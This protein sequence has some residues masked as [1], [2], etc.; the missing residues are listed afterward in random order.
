MTQEEKKELIM[1]LCGYLPYDLKVDVC[2]NDGQNIHSTDIVSY[3]NISRCV[4]LVEGD[5]VSIKPYLRP[6]S[7]MTPEEEKEFVKFHC[8]DLCPIIMDDC[9]TIENETEMIN[10]L[11]ARHFDYRK[12]KDGKTMIK[13]GIA[14]EA[15]EN[16]Y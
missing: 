3:N 2:I 14:I 12:N 10:W 4:E 16:M 11:N 6:L 5:N 13:R 8:V 15:L 7:S 1:A 9:L